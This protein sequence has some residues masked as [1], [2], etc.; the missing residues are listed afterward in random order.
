MSTTIM[1]SFFIN[2]LN[3]LMNKLNNVSTFFLSSLIM[4]IRLYCNWNE[5]SISIKII[6]FDRFWSTI[7]FIWIDSILFAMNSSL[8]FVSQMKILRMYEINDDWLQKMWSIVFESRIFLVMWLF[9]KFT[10]SSDDSF[11]FLRRFIISVISSRL[12]E[13]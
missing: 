9:T 5:K 10:K 11:S 8:M 7:S 12:A 3:V 1:T 2:N 6:N 4:L 13:G